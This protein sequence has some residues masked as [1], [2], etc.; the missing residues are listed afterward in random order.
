[1]VGAQVALLWSIEHSPSA[2]LE[3]VGRLP[4]ARVHFF[5]LPVVGA[6]RSWPAT[7]CSA[8]LSSEANQ[9]KKNKLWF[10]CVNAVVQ[11]A[12]IPSLRLHPLGLK[13]LR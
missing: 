13:A 5:L 10:E 6:K 2:L 3:L 7:G 12:Q 11:K 4:A 1:M 9:E 8:R